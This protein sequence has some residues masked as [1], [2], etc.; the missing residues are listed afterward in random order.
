MQTMPSVVSQ[1]PLVVMHAQSWVGEPH[2]VPLDEEAADN[3]HATRS[4]AD[5]GTM[6]TSLTHDVVLAKTVHDRAV[7]A[8][9][10][11]RVKLRSTGGGFTLPSFTKN[12]TCMSEA[13]QSWEMTCWALIARALD[14]SQL[15]VGPPPL[16]TV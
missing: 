8:M 3:F 4:P 15:V 14:V 16:T 2:V 12:S 11:T 7:S 10:T 6:S 1:T 13:T 5:T 9:L